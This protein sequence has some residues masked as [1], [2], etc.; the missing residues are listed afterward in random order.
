MRLFR[1]SAAWLACVLIGT[2]AQAEAPRDPLNLVPDQADFCIKI[3]Q[4]R[5]LVKTILKSDLVTEVQKIDAVRELYDSTN[6]HRVYQL[7]AYF[8]KKLGANRYELLDHLASNGIVV[9]GKFGDQAPALLV[10]QGKDEGLLRRFVELGT[11]VLEQELARQESK[12]HVE[13]SNYRGIQTLR[14]GKDLHAAVVGTALLITNKD[15]ALH[16]ALDLHAD[17]PKKSLAQ[18]ASVT[19]A[20]QQV[21][22]DPLAWL[23]LNLETVRKNP[24]AKEV[25]AMPRNDFQLTV[26]F[27]GWLDVARRAPYLCAAAYPEEHGLLLSFRMPCGREGMPAELA[28]HVPPAGQP[29]SRPLLEPQGVLYSTSYH[30][31]ISKFWEHRAKLFNE[32]QIKAFEDF[33]KNSGTFLAGNK[34]SKI[35]A[36]AGPYQRV[37]VVN[38]SKRPYK[39][40]PGQVYPAFAVVTEMREP[41]AFTKR[42]DAILRAAALFATTQVKLKPVEETYHERKIAGYRFPEDGTFKADVNNIRFNFSPCFVSVGNQFV[43]CSTFELC[44]ELVDLLNK[45]GKEAPKGDLAT[46]RTRLYA[47]GGAQVMEAFQ[48]RLVTQTILDQA[49]PPERATQQVQILTAL[50]R[51]LGVLQI[52]ACYGAKDFHYDFRL[53]LAQ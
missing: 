18:L 26:L 22:P 47:S 6:A 1:F 15:F 8:E 48:D 12:D 14:I 43:V 35:A 27:G 34:F 44:R 28:P 24:Q 13:K 38:Q 11:E 30:L 50:A 5:K 32:K 19:Q 9:A 16:L 36:M 17:G 29:G 4:P 52:E 33:D 42:M 3:E 53:K 23:W 7:L 40:E 46:V 41:E 39:V 2:V 10:L 51:R 25:F 21:S 49:I 31:D 20:R 37:V 45:E